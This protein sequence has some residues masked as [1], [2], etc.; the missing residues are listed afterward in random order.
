MMRKQHQKFVAKTNSVHKKSCT[1]IRTI[2]LY[3][4]MYSIFL[5]I[6]DYGTEFP[7]LSGHFQTLHKLRCPN[8]EMS[9]L[10]EYLQS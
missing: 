8:C 5:I 4:F 3:V 2:G 6:L 10:G 9:R 7:H 1:Y